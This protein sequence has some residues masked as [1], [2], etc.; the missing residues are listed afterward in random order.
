M[1]KIDREESPFPP[2]ECESGH[3]AMKNFYEV[4]RPGSSQHL[5]KKNV[6]EAYTS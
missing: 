6:Q 5:K 4:I 1:K 2:D 3:V